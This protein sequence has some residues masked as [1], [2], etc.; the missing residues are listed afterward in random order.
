[1]I[2]GLLTSIAVAGSTYVNDVN[3][4]SLRNQTF[5]GVDKVTIDADGN[6]RIFAPG[7]DIQVVGEPDPPPPGPSVP[8]TPAVAP[9]TSGSV[10]MLEPGTVDNGVPMGR[11]WLITEDNGSGGHSIAVFINGK[12]MPAIPSGQPQ[13]IQDIQAYVRPG[14]NQVRVESNSAA[15]SGGTFYVYL[16]SGSNES[17][18]VIMDP[19]QVQFG[20]GPSRDG[21]YVRE[22]TL[23][24][25]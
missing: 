17:G 13:L 10:A 19:P 18:T 14:E 21:K 11:W 24:V 2:L 16:G 9:S 12:Q 23:T 20:V 25:R 22:Y 3:V 6:V 8:D 15:A 7:Y 5:V 1:M 4:D